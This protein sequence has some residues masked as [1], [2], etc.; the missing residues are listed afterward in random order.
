MQGLTVSVA[1]VCAL[2]V[3][4]RASCNCTGQ[5]WDRPPLLLY[6]HLTQQIMC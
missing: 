3:L 5:L 6:D 1:V 4:V 2:I